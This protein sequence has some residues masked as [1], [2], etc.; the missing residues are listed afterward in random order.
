MADYNH[1]ADSHSLEINPDQLAAMNSIVQQSVVDDAIKADQGAKRLQQFGDPAYLP[2]VSLEELY[3]QVFQSKPPIIDDLL[4]PGVYIFAGPPKIGKS[5]LVAQVSYH[6]SKGLPLW[7]YFVHQG[8]VLYLA[9]EDNYR[10]LQ[11]R[12]YRMYGT[13]GTPNLHFA[14]CAKQLGYGLED[15]LQK[16][17]KDNPDTKLI[18]IDTLQKIREGGAEK[19]SYASD[20]DVIGKLKSLAD[21]NGICILL[22]HHT[23]KQQADDKFDMISGTNGLLGAADGA[24][25]MQKE[26]RTDN[27]AYIEISGRDQQDQRLYLRRDEDRLIWEL[28]RRETELWREPP[29]LVLKAVSS[30]ISEKSP[31]WKGTAT[32]LVVALGLEMKANALARLLNIRASKLRYDYNI[33]Y[34]SSRNHSGRSITLTRV[35]PDSPDS[36]DGRDDRDDAPQSV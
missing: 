25:I 21:R 2:T 8:G 29:D 20:Y 27:T 15:Q 31:C 28:E 18:V 23:R 17:V 30:L 33:T 26:K 3:D 19:Y 1:V 16:F 6:V 4:N 24:L 12:L 5:F 7:D 10:R 34:T 22:V 9:L 36:R 11:E 13:E 14:I 35:R 32:D